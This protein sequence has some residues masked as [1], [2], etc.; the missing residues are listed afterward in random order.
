MLTPRTFQSDRGAGRAPMDGGI[1][2]TWYERNLSHG[3]AL[4]GKAAS[5]LCP[6]VCVRACVR[7]RAYI[8]VCVCVA[9]VQIVVFTDVCDCCDV[10]DVPYLYT[11]GSRFGHQSSLH[12]VLP[13]PRVRIIVVCIFNR[14]WS[15]LGVATCFLIY[16][17]VRTPD[18]V[19]CAEGKGGRGDV[20]REFA[21]AANEWGIKICYYSN[22]RDDGYLA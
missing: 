6:Q 9:T 11:R 4:W 19:M 17:D 16:A 1:R 7:V 12:T 5:T 13:P 14:H 2:I 20:L 21:D 8:S 10:T 15:A 18:A 3:K 22:P